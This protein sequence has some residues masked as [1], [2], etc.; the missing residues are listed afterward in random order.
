MLQAYEAG[1]PCHGTGFTSQRHRFEGVSYRYASSIL[2]EM[3]DPDDILLCTPSLGSQ[4]P[5]VIDVLGSLLPLVG[6]VFGEPQSSVG[7]KTNFKRD[8]NELIERLENEVW[9]LDLDSI[10]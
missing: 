7:G 6:R 8:F 3:D 10:D 2:K 4:L 5:K 9:G 1:I